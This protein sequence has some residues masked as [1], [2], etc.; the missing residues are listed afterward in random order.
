[1][2]VRKSPVSSLL[3]RELPMSE[4]GG[5]VT[6]TLNGLVNHGDNLNLVI[7]H[8]MRKPSLLKLMKGTLVFGVATAED[9]SP[10]RTEP[11]RIYEARLATSHTIFFDDHRKCRECVKR[12]R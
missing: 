11:N 3:Y 1:M 7:A 9:S 8:E 12:E 2:M 4:S 10:P 5:T 6:E